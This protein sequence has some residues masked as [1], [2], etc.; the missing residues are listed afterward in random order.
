MSVSRRRVLRASAWS[1]PVVAAAIAVPMV[2]A[3][4]V[5][6]SLAGIPSTVVVGVPI[7]TGSVMAAGNSGF[8][9][10]VT[11]PS[12]FAWTDGSPSGARTIGSGEG[13]FAVPPFQATTESS[14]ATL[15]AKTASETASAQ[16]V[17]VGTYSMAALGGVD[18]IDAAGSE[19]R[20]DFTIVVPKGV[21]PTGLFCNYT[22]TASVA[23][24]ALTKMGNDGSAAVQTSV[25]QAYGI[26]AVQSLDGGYERLYV[27]ARGDADIPNLASASYAWQIRASWPAHADTT[28]S[29]PV[30]QQYFGDPDGRP[31]AVNAWDYTTT[32]LPGYIGPNAQTGWGNVVTAQSSVNPNVFLIDAYASGRT[33]ET[34]ND[35]TTTVLYQF[36]H[37]D[38]TPAAITAT[39][40]SVTIPNH[41]SGVSG[42]YLGVADS[43]LG[44]VVF[45]RPGYWKLLIWP[46]SSNSRPTSTATPDGVAWDPST[47]P[48][49]QVGSV[50]WKIPTAA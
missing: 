31:A 16:I 21:R 45:D 34:G 24:T 7:V 15:V 43:G 10:S 22:P 19:F 6:L 20:A 23:T 25:D 14:G 48:G 4:G 11:L 44:A 12:G 9:V 35:L 3:S 18:V 38:G 36:V 29:L 27:S 26:V 30:L 28:L 46:Q 42:V 47:D 37:E 39:P 1:V 40:R 50:F 17:A 32:S 5:K 8:A 13:T 49:A 33:P 41:T 2:A